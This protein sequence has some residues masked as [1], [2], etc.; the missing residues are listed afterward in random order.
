[1]GAVTNILNSFSV[2]GEY[3]FIIVGAG[4]AGS[5]IASRLSEIKKW[6]ILLLEAG[7]YR[8]DDLTEIPSLWVHDG[9]T[10]FNWGFESVPQKYGCLGKYLNLFFFCYGW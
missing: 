2:Y 3:D 6:K 9:F 10:K 5:I 7:T 8:D 1:M 4:A